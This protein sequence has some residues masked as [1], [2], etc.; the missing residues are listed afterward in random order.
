MVTILNIAELE[1]GR[2]ANL[3]LE[4]NIT[5]QIVDGMPNEM[6]LTPR[7]K[8]DIVALSALIVSG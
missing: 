7:D 1:N 2:L 8:Q 3:S 6:V 5:M 4:E